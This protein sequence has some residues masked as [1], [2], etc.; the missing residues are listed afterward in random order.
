MKYFIVLLLVI[1]TGKSYAQYDSIAVAILD[2]MS[3]EISELETCSFR[4]T[5][6]YDIPNDEFGLITHSESG[7]VYMKGPDKIF[8]EKKGDKGHKSFFYNGKTMLLYSFDKNQYA[9][10]PATMSLIELIDSISSYYGV[11]F[12]GVDVFYP[13]FVDNLL[14]TSN[15]LIYLGLA[16]VGNTECYHIA[17]ARDDMTF[18]FWIS[19][20]KYSLLVKMSIVY[21]TKP[22]DPRYSIVFSDW[23]LD[24]NIDDSKFEFSLPE[25]AL[26]VKLIK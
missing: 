10:A 14:E 24:E 16:M 6:E 12:P 11:E 20:D 23:K 25:G 26:L 5:S 22:E 19:P 8:V 3:N 15:N 21:L 7:I 4:Y 13:D 18:Q 1:F 2:S 17:G 9:S